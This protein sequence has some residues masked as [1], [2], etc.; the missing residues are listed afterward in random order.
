MMM[1]LAGFRAL[2]ALLG[3][4]THKKTGMSLVRVKGTE[5]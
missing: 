3:R 1:I 2:P 5:T 4:A